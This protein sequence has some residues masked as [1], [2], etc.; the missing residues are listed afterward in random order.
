MAI[1]I[2]AD[3]ADALEGKG[4]DAC[5]GRRHGQV[6]RLG[7]LPKATKLLAG[8]STQR[9]C[10]ASAVSSIMLHDLKWVDYLGGVHH[11]LVV[12]AYEKEFPGLKEL[13]PDHPDYATAVS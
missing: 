7:S 9:V 5:A 2:Y 4:D 1:D 3:N 12:Q 13:S 8:M 11:K 6:K 10:V